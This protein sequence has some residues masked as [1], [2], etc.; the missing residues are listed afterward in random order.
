[1]S[2]THGQERV[3]CASHMTGEQYEMIKTASC[4]G[5]GHQHVREMSQALHCRINS[6]RFDIAHWRT[7][8]SHVVV[9]FNNVAHSVQD[10]AVM[11]L[12]KHIHQRSEDAVAT[13]NGTQGRQPLT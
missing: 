12:E 1:M 3:Y 2:N 4:K 8:K 10:V 5:C 7:D 11:V 6:H 9:H 13:N